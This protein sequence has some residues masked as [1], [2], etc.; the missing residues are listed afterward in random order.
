MNKAKRIARGME[1]FRLINEAT[2]NLPKWQAE[3]SGLFADGKPETTRSKTKASTKKK[4]KTET[5]GGNRNG[6]GELT[7][8]L[9]AALKS[10]PAEFTGRE[11]IAA[12]SIK[13]EDEPSAF[14]AISRMDLKSHE[15]KKSTTSPG[16]YR[17]AKGEEK[18]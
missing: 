13:K 1:L 16:K 3:L 10:M 2:E 6:R 5:T 15:I 11:L 8:A 12:A 7:A 14:A 4:T 17:R 9:R 18:M